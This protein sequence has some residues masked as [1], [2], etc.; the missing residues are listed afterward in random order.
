M[1][2]VRVCVCVCVCAC[3]CACVC[4]YFLNFYFDIK[5]YQILIKRDNMQVILL[6]QPK[7]IM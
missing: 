5:F 7:L 6:V 4:F 2:C 1:L 3:V